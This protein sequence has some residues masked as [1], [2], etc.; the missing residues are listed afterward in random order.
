MENLLSRK[1]LYEVLP[2]QTQ[3][4]SVPL[5]DL[6]EIEVFHRE[7]GLKNHPVANALVKLLI[8]ISGFRAFAEQLPNEIDRLLRTVD[9]RGSAL[10]NPVIAAS[11]A[12][13]DD[14]RSLSM[15]QRAAV[16]ILAAYD[17]HN[18]IREGLLA[19][20]TYRDQPLE[21][22]QYA[23]FFA[24]SQII[25]NGR[26]R[27]FK[28]PET[29]YITVLVH[30]QMYVLTVENKE[31]GRLT[32]TL[33]AIVA[34]GRNRRAEYGDTTPGIIAATPNPFQIKAFERLKSGKDHQHNLELL[35]HSFFTLAL[36]PEEA[37]EDEAEAVRVGHSHHYENRW[38]R[39]SFQMIVFNNAR[40]CFT[41]SFSAYLTGNVMMR[42]S[43]EIY[44]RSLKVGVQSAEMLDDR[45]PQ[46]YE[47]LHWKIPKEM[48]QGAVQILK[49]F[50]SEQK[51]TFTFDFIG[52]RLLRCL[53]LKP[54]PAF[55]AAL[56]MAAY[57][58][59]EKHPKIQQFV[60]MSKYCCMDVI[61]GNIT[62]RQM[63][64]FCE[65][66]KQTNVDAEVTRELLKKAID[67]QVEAVRERRSALPL[68]E[69]MALFWQTRSTWHRKWLMMT[70]APMLF[71]LRKLNLMSRPPREVIISH[72]EISENVPV[73]GRPGV[74]LPYVKYFGLH[75]QIFEEHIT[76]TIMPGLKWQTG[77]KILAERIE[78]A[79]KEILRIYQT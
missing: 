66:M 16:L 42:G 48:Q 18:A 63:I 53:G 49:P 76:I 20:D 13:K 61:T 39:S 2:N 31:G 65:Y 40:V 71:L 59:I 28:S 78:R 56:Q 33:E 17:L 75:Y 26:A 74:R 27:I 51:A 7:Y 64:D 24:T 46:P 79:L 45:R 67:S 58:L 3:L 44:Q 35:K 1:E 73:I 19:Q 25:V 47:R 6:R 72:P 21:M 22:G 14:E 36:E 43:S 68:T 23:N 57:E 34:D 37:P 10:F 70:V 8:H 11:L 41:C 30:G 9:T 32:Q 38:F 60:T 69:I 29:R 77:N 12:V 5:P 15:C 54:I 50:L 52:G 62:T 4:P 55:V